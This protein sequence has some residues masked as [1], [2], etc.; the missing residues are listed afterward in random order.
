[1]TATPAGY[2]QLAMVEGVLSGTCWTAPTLSHARLYLRNDQG[3]VV[4]LDI[5]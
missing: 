3:A 1:V 4:C 2:R 5:K